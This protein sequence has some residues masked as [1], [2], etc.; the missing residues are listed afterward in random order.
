MV[1]LLLF[2][3]W[4]HFPNLQLQLLTRLPQQ[5]L[6]G[7]KGGAGVVA[8]DCRAAAPQAPVTGHG[9]GP[10]SPLRGLRLGPGWCH[11]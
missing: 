4:F 11:R 7:R 1:L 6:P 10:H 2:H 3:G 9:S 8:A 5:L